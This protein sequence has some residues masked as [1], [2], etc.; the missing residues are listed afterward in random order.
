[1]NTANFLA[2]PASRRTAS[3][4]ICYI[5]GGF[6]PEA[7][8]RVSVFDHGLLYGDGVFDTVVAWK[9]SLFRLDDHVARLFRSMKAVGLDVEFSGDDL[10]A[11]TL[12][13][14]VLNGLRD[15]YVKWIVTRGSNDTPL[16]DP[17]GC[18]P[19]LIIVVRPYIERFTA[20]A[21]K[22]ISL[23]T[24]AIRRTPAQ[25]L[26][27]GVKNLNYLNLILAKMEAKAAQ[28]DEALMLD[29]QG[30]ICEAPGYNVFVVEGGRLL[31]PNRDIL[32]GITRASVLDLARSRGIETSEQDIGL[33]R[34]YTAE[35]V[36]LTSTAG[37]LIPITRVDGRTIG[38]G[39]PGPVYAALSRAYAEILGSPEWG[40][41]VEEPDEIATE[42]L[43]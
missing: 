13:A 23:K 10:K 15:A 32:E 42:V 21:D 18:H 24:V 27:P 43:Q 9:G 37:G 31:T 2:S 22:G 34:A 41:P 5:D 20:N 7:E 40:V 36:F 28:C 12:R 4:R 25:C 29:L 16:M 38:A 14:V 8:A 35:E 30:N 11:L 17:A 6:V 3:D 26:D 1:M 33:Y 39:R 19:N